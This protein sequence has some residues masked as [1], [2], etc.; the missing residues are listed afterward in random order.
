MDQ[1]KI[2][3]PFS[4]R[5]GSDTRI[6]KLVQGDQILGQVV[7][8]NSTGTVVEVDPHRGPVHDLLVRDAQRRGLL[9]GYDIPD[10]LQHDLEQR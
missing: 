4:P 9:H 5:E 1:T 3:G 6:L 7:Y 2:V 10:H 8:Y